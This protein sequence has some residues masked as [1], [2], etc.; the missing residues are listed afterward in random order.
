M[1]QL[2]PVP[3]DMRAWV[4]ELIGTREYLQHLRACKSKY[5][6]KWQQS[7]YEYYAARLDL[8]LSNPPKIPTRYRWNKYCRGR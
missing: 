3:R 7:Q 6:P 1:I 5:L 4:R 2:K 8:I